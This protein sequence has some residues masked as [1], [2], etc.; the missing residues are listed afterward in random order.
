MSA[1]CKYRRRAS[2]RIYVSLR[3]AGQSPINLQ[4]HARRR[5]ASPAALPRSGRGSQPPV[6]LGPLA[7]SVQPQC[8][9]PRSPAAGGVRAD[10]DPVEHGLDGGAAPVGVP[11][12]PCVA[13]RVRRGDVTEHGR[14]TGKPVVFLAGPGDAVVGALLDVEPVFLV[15][16]V[17]GQSRRA[18]ARLSCARRISSSSSA[19][20]G[21]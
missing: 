9:I 2:A 15:D 10:R 8:T 17:L 14:G 18:S 7:E 12:L 21:A 16:D 5:K 4:V 1:P 6:E 3:I 11:V 13:H 19:R 20:R